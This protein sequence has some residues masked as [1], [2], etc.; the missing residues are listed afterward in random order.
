MDSQK[1]YDYKPDNWVIAKIE[2]NDQTVYKLVAGW[3]GGYLD[4]DTWRV[5]SGIT[6]VTE[7]DSY[8]YFGGSS[9]SVYKCFKNAYTVRMNISGIVEFITH[10]KDHNC[11]IMPEDTD[12]MSVDWNN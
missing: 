8:F 10:A 9:G 5:N 2:D 6:E 7:D 1:S 3:S 12:W 4:G 11:T